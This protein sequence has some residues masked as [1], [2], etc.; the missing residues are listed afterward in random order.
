VWILVVAI[1]SGCAAHTTPERFEF[2]RLCM[3]VQTKIVTWGVDRDAASAAAAKAFDRIGEL[4]ASFS[5]YQQKSE[6]N[7][8]SDAAGGSPVKVSDPLLLAISESIMVSHDSGGAFDITVGPAVQLWRAARRS[9]Q[10]APADQIAAAR[11]L[12]GFDSIIVDHAK[13]TV[14]LRRP[15]MRLDLGGIGKGFAAQRALEIMQMNGH[16][17]TLVSLAG[18]IAVGDPPP[19]QAG[20]KVALEGERSGH[21]IGTLLLSNAAVST[22]GDTEQSVV[23]GGVSYSHII[24]PKTGLG[25]TERRSA[26]VISFQGE[27]ADALSTAACLL[28]PDASRRMLANYPRTAAVF[29]QIT[30]GGTLETVIDPEGVVRWAEPPAVAPAAP[31]R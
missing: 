2:T 10:M 20:W 5:D 27:F 19:G 22:S 14:Q 9:G 23:I 25:M 28:G 7:R 8:L 30:P 11:A 29:E 3:G 17:R 21:R 15:G 6:L 31:A 16:R 4:D 24:D 13:H 26:S 18:D 1:L 12:I